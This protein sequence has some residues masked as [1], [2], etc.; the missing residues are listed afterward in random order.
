MIK[1]ILII[2]FFP[3]LIVG[4][5]CKKMDSGEEPVT[6]AQPEGSYKSAGFESNA[7]TGNE[8]ENAP[9]VQK[10]VIKEARMTI[11]TESFKK[12]TQSVHS[13]VKKWEGYIASEDQNN[14]RWKRRTDFVLRVGGRNF[15]SLLSQLE[16]LPA[17]VERKQTMIKDVTEEFIDLRA[18]LKAKRALEDRYMDL[19]KEAENVKEVLM[20]EEELQK[21]REE[22]EAKQGRLKY[23][24]NRVSYSTINLKL[25]QPKEYKA[26]E[27]GFVDRTGEALGN[28]WGYFL[29]FILALLNIWPFLLL[30]A[31]VIGS[32]RF[33]IKKKKK[34]KRG[35]VE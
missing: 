15:D 20:V 35:K 13:L 29:N 10:Q 26:E 24:K 19:L 12:A 9:G 8:S 17:E 6:S 1:R 28:G 18:R 34:K 25:Y 4:Y 7:A 23:L 11:M 5:S 27:E 22:I 21:I 3:L 2:C 14:T 33:Y 31:G 32:L 30:I 16:S